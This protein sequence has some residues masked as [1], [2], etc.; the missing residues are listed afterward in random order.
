VVFKTDAALAAGVARY[1]RQV[2]LYAA[3]VAG[4]TG[5]PARAVLLQV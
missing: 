5:R 3:A 1:R 2:R 4:A